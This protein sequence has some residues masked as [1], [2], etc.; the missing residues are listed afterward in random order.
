V[1]IRYSTVFEAELPA[2]SAAVTVTEWRPDVVVSSGE[3][4]D[5]RVQ[6]AT[7]E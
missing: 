3:V 7:P 1:P 5:V 4:P 2:R 6:V